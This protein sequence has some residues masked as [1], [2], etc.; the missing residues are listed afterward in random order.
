MGGPD[1][2]VTKW[3]TVVDSAAGEGDV[4]F[5]GYASIAGDR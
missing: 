3:N 1:H 2:A 4:E 5:T